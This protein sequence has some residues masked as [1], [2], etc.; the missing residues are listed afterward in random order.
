MRLYN[1]LGYDKWSRQTDYGNRRHGAEGM[2]S[3]AKRKF[4]EN[5][6]VTSRRGPVAEAVQIMWAY[7]MLKY[8]RERMM[9]EVM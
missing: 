3:A 1:R 8:Y 6:M 9:G 4:G 7:D 2:Y 5:L